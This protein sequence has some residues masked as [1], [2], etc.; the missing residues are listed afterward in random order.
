MQFAGSYHIVVSEHY[1]FA[2]RSID[3]CINWRVVAEGETTG[4]LLQSQGNPKGTQGI[5]KFNAQ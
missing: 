2:I 3:A 4:V 1:Y 5:S